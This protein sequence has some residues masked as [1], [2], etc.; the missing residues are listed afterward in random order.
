MASLASLPLTDLL[1][2]FSAPEPTPG[3]GSAAAVGGALGA[4]LLVMV[5]R[6]PKTRHGGLDETEA[7]G[8]IVQ[9]LLGV[10]DRLAR[11]ADQDMA[12]YQG[13]TAAFRLPKS[14]D[15]EK[16]ARTGA[17]RAAM[18]RATDVPLDTMRAAVEALEHAGTVA[19]MGNR[20]AASDAAAGI[21]LLFAALKGAEG[22]VRIN[23]ASLPQDDYH[24]QTTADADRL[25]DVGASLAEQ[26]GQALGD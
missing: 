7:L 8:A 18:R 22:N 6:L 19:R 16:A 20:N 10:R 9:P 25:A 26:A 17:I 4:A 13:V 2:A 24:V 1:D 5:A 14:N 12:A 3:G 11:L 21:A 23:L 15:D